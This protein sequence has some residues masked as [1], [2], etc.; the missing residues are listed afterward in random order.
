MG[1]A[2]LRLPLLGGRER[3]VIRMPSPVSQG[4]GAGRT[5]RH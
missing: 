1:G 5:G 2:H 4:A 3:D